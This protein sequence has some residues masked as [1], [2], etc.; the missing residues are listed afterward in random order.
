MT[1]NVEL[2]AFGL[3][4]IKVYFMQISKVIFFNNILYAE[5]SLVAQVHECVFG[6]N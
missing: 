1:L 6:S 2:A 4:N 3:L 5:S